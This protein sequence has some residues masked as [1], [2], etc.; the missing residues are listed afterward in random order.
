MSDA[1]ADAAKRKI[2]LSS[3]TLSGLADAAT[4]SGDALVAIVEAT[5]VQLETELAAIPRWRWI[6]RWFFGRDLK[7]AVNRQDR[8][9]RDF[10]LGLADE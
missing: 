10:A 3:E 2:G 8:L 9:R 1:I 5:V 4:R 7:I 6:K